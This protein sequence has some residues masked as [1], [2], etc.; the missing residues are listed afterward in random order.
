MGR[1]GA[2]VWI[3]WD[4][5]DSKRARKSRAGMD[6][7]RTSLTEGCSVGLWSYW[8]GDAGSY[9]QPDRKR[10]TGGRHTDS[11]GYVFWAQ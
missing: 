4:E 1:A 6:G 5:W 11:L 7:L 8:R 10:W 3:E 2:H 9:L